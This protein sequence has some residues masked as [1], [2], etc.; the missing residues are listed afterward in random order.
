MKPWY[1]QMD[2]EVPR[3][4]DY[5]KI[6]AYGM[7]AQAAERNPNGV[8]TLFFGAKI[9]YAELL[10]RVDRF[11]DG[12]AEL[13]VRKGDRVAIILPN[14]PA[15]PI[16]HFAVLRLGAIL[17]PTN[18][19]YV[20]RE[21]AHQLTDSGAETAVVFD[22]LL[23]K[24]EAVRGQT[25]V[26]RVIVAGIRE[27]LPP[28]LGLLFGLKDKSGLRLDGSKG[29]VSFR[30]MLGKNA[31]AAPP[32][33]VTP[34]DTAILLYTGGTTGVSK[35]AVLTHRNILVN[36]YQTR[37]WLWQLEDTRETLLC[38]LPFFHSYGMTTGLHL[39]VVLS[40]TMLLLPRFDLN[41]VVKRIGKH[42]PT[43]FCGVPSMY[44]AVNNHPKAT[45]KTVGSIRLCVSGGSGLP[46][47]VQKAFETLT[48]ASL[49][50]GFG[51]S[52]AS[53]VTH[54][55]PIA[56]KRKIGTIGLPVS[57]TDSM[58]VDPE[59]RKPLAP[60]QQGELAVKGPQ[61]MKGYWNMADETAAVLQD[62]WLY[63]GDIAVMD[64]E[65]FFRIVDRK[66][67]L[68][69]SAGMNIYPREVEE[70]LYQH[71]KVSEAAVVGIPS[72]VRDEVVKAFI[73]AKPGQTLTRGELLQFCRDKLAK[74]KVPKE[75]ELR[76]SLPKS[77][78]GKI[79]K[80]VLRDEELNKRPTKERK[81]E[82]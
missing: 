67:D 78:A 34:E 61:V 35:G 33:S 50:E 75:I 27:F 59:T 69:I 65:G 15:Y 72:A 77:A 40:S 73:V 20:E 76:D 18:P 42:R 11:A 7:L 58:I 48:G 52:E 1:G 36:A 45:P 22:K 38:V 80:R 74:F 56:G 25:P 3:S 57:D 41:D 70:V 32:V 4:I 37:H 62:G 53:P 13:G 26:K 24:L 16:A 17:V 39:S 14:I 8:A 47:E 6:S 79:L 49:V 71:P 51:L 30:A 46:M 10:R 43:V 12:L 5:P 63:T 9:R 60:G 68:I 55:N 44:N 82:E 28:V 66:K 23:P 54:V 31:P 81:P 21:L 29:Q 19:L 64:E 2:P